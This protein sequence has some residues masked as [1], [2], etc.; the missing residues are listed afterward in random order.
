[1]GMKPY[2]QF[3]AL[4]FIT[5]TAFSFSFATYVMFLLSR[6]ASLFEVG[7]INISFMLAI[8]LAE[9]P[10]GIFADLLGRKR[11][12]QISC[13]IMAI[14]F[15]IYYLSQSFWMFI[16]AETL[17]GIGLTFRSGALQA[18]AIDSIRETGADIPNE[19]LFSSE[20]I[21]KNAANI[22]GGLAGAYMGDLDL[23]YPF[24]AG[25]V[26]L[27]ITLVLSSIVMR[28]PE[29]HF[30]LTRQSPFAAVKSIFKR[31]VD[32]GLRE[33]TVFMLMMTALVSALFYQPLNMYWQPRFAEVA[34]GK[35]WILGW[36][37]VFIS[38]S[39]MLGGYLIKLIPRRY[40]RYSVLI[41]TV[42]LN[43]LP[44]IL[45]AVVRDFVIVL[46]FFGMYEIARGMTEPI[47]L[48]LLNDSIPSAERATILSLDQVFMR[49]G[50][51]LGL[52]FT[53]LLADNYSI[54]IAWIVAAIVGL[55]NIPILVSIRKK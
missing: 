50:A 54:S 47:R 12:F 30:D 27:V 38:G 5:R 8:A 14:G 45:A 3:L 13:F 32:Y 20:G 22:T 6:N 18:W 51:V 19:R 35:I 53:G 15:F 44:V 28:E 4:T 52:L 37:W 29:S 24:L 16:V 46:L 17:A 9:I 7:L 23:A 31:S 43:S 55:I 40:N 42:L 36:I 10:T 2:R 41:V 11:S 49:T 34:N 48:A 21:A 26:V 33:K 1:M 39:L 25:A